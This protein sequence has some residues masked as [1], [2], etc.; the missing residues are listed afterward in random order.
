MFIKKKDVL[1]ILKPKSLLIGYQNEFMIVMNDYQNWELLS[2][3]DCF[4]SI[5]PTSAFSPGPHTAKE[6]H[7][8]GLIDRF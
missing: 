2:F 7:K 4:F 1:K 3:H 5:K 6:I 8:T